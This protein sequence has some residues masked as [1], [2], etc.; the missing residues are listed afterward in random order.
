M[1]SITSTTA[2]AGALLLFVAPMA[3]TLEFTPKSG[4]QITRTLTA[5]RSMEME[6][7]KLTFMDHEI[8]LGDGISMT[9]TRSAVL[10]DS[11]DKVEDGLILEFT[12]FYETIVDDSET[13]DGDGAAR[14]EAPDGD[15]SDL[16]GKSVGFAWDAEEDAYSA[17]Y[18]GNEPGEDEWLD[19][20]TAALDFTEWLPSEDVDVGDKWEIP[21]EELASALWFGGRL[22]PILPVEH[23]E[24]PEGAISIAVP[25]MNDA[26]MLNG[27]EES[28][29][30]TLGSVEG[31]D[32]ARVAVVALEWKGT[33]EQDLT[34]A[35]AELGEAR[36]DSHGFDAAEQVIELSGTG[37]LRWGLDSGR[38]VA[39]TLDVD[40]EIEENAEWSTSAH[41]MD[42]DLTYSSAKT[43]AYHIELTCEEAESDE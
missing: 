11:I 2:F 29:V 17:R 4:V 42:L 43:E 41:D 36:G 13:E 32:G 8:D 38:L 40:L 26:H 18:A 21:M 33:L 23:E 19:G 6:Y 9:S 14:V 27:S 35:L 34:E 20:L 3:E 31:E 37:E 7:S 28:L 5:E 15:P 12:R 16:Q 22:Y 30:L 10:V 39:L 24:G 1:F 25:N